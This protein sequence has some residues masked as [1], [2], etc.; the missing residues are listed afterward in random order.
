MR[1][2]TEYYIDLE[3]FEAWSGA[4]YTLDRLREYGKC[5]ELEAILEEEY[6]D[7]IDETKLN[8]I[9]WF[10]DDWCYEMVGI[11]TEEQQREREEREREEKIDELFED[12]CGEQGS[13]DDPCGGCPYACNDGSVVECMSAWCNDHKKEIEEALKL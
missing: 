7:G 10:D 9:L 12:F 4:Q 13:D 3:N 8:D 1:I 5:D 2:T 11:E 6:P